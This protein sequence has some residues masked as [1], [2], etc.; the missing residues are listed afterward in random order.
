VLFSSV[1]A[2]LADSIGEQIRAAASGAN[3]ARDSVMRFTRACLTH[4][5]ELFLVYGITP[6]VAV[7]L[8]PLADEMLSGFTQGLTDY[9]AGILDSGVKSGEFRPC[10]TARVSAAI[11]KTLEGL[12]WTMLLTSKA[13]ESADLGGTIRDVQNIV[14][15]VLDGIASQPSLSTT[16]ETN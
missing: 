3:S 6:R 12:N 10:D 8:K 9:L 2:E 14:G 16:S 11:Q 4:T 7:E 5:R 15:L 1:V 13:I